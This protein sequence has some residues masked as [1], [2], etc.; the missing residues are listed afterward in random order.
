MSV[1]VKICGLTNSTDALKACELGADYLGFILYD[2]SPRYIEPTALKSLCD[3]L[4][5]STQRVGVFVNAP[6]NVILETVSECALSIVQ[7]H[8]DEDLNDYSSL[9]VPIW[10]AVRISPES[11][12]MPNDSD[13][14]ERILVDTSVDGL[15][16]GSG[17]Q[18]DLPAAARVAA[19]Y[20]T[21]LGGGMSPENVANSISVVHPLGVDVS[22]G[23]ESAPGT[24]DH[25]KLEA[26]FAA[27]RSA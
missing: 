3:A 18:V 17:K 27:V 2:R 23:V 15:Y 5:A 20:K 8:G 21:M 14:A 10:K 1:E 6:L 16:G 26:F 11:A 19:A 12:D 4:P 9:P 7:L 24:K 13:L 25:A 22:S